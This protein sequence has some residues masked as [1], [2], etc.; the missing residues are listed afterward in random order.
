MP[1]LL[2]AGEA[3]V[4]AS[5]NGVRLLVSGQG[6]YRVEGNAA[7]LS[8]TLTERVL[9]EPALAPPGAMTAAASAGPVAVDDEIWRRLAAFATRT[10]VPASAASR[11]RGAGAGLSDND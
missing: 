10:C 3:G 9:V 7:A 1:F 4:A 5:W 11:A 2:P 6:R 8:A